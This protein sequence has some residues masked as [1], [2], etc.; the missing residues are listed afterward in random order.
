MAVTEPL[1]TDKGKVTRDKGKVTRGNPDD[2]AANG[3]L[4]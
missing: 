1:P 4:P 3:S 2:P